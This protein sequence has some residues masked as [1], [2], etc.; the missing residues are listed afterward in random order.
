[1]WILNN[2]NKIVW[3]YIRQEIEPSL[4]FLRNYHKKTFAK[5]LNTIWIVYYYVCKNHHTIT[6]KISPYGNCIMFAKMIMK[7]ICK[8]INLH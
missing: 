4:M 6:F 3:K 5:K 7:N 1:M 2:F 8:E